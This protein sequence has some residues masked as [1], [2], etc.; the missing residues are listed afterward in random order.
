M[1]IID[2]AA[3]MSIGLAMMSGCRT[4]CNRTDR[5]LSYVRRYI[6]ES[7]LSGDINYSFFNSC[8]YGTKISYMVIPSEISPPGNW[9]SAIILVTSTHLL[10]GRLHHT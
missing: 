2:L 5:A 3:D 10:T 4:N 1:P 9:Y 6:D 8:W 7:A